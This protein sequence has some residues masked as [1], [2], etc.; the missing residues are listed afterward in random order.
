MNAGRHLIRR[1]SMSWKN[2]GRKRKRNRSY[3]TY[4]TCFTVNFSIVDLNRAQDL[5]ERII[6]S[7][8]VLRGDGDHVEQLPVPQLRRHHAHSLRTP[9]GFVDVTERREKRVPS[10]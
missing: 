1:R 7:A 4:R 3:R 10:G 6:K 8:F 2:C 9:G 5:L